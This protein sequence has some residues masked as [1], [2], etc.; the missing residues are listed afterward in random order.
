M[1]GKQGRSRDFI[2]QAINFPI[3]GQALTS[4]FINSKFSSPSNIS[5]SSYKNTFNLFAFTAP[6]TSKHPAYNDHIKACNEF[7]ADDIIEQS[8]H[9]AVAMRRNAFLGGKQNSLT[10]VLSCIGN[11]SSMPAPLW[12]LKCMTLILTHWFCIAYLRSPLS[13][14]TPNS[15]HSSI[16]P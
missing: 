1:V 14:T 13:S 15:I 11:F 6:P 7:A 2:L 5:I 10:D 3:Q 8:E 12:T 9:A 4:Y 16:I